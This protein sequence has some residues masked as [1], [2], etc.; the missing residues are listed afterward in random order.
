MEALGFFGLGGL[1][2]NVLS[3]VNKGDW[4][5]DAGA[6]VGLVTAG[7]CHRVGPSGQVWAI[8][9][10]PRNI[11]RLNTYRED[12]R[13]PWL[14]IIAGAVGATSGSVLLHLPAG[15]ESGWAS[16]T[17]SWE[18]RG[19]IPVESY[20][21]DDLV[22]EEAVEQPVAFCKID[23]E[24]AEPSV[25]KGAQRM[26]EEMRPLVFCE[27]NDILLR[28]AGYSAEELL[29]AFEALRYRPADGFS[30]QAK[31]LSGAVVDLL[32]ESR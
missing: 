2:T 32:L 31:K 28:D 30:E 17:K 15:G 3:R 29:V 20:T 21:L 22:F 11:A 18:T 4:A 8:E 9:P 12:N 24:G 1:P 25:L 14:R 5:I 7:L 27:F 26:L 16:L 13:L 19:S 23:V 6:N 10:L